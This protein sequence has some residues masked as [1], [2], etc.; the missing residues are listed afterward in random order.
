MINRE[1]THVQA[2]D[3]CGCCHC[4]CHKCMNTNGHCGGSQCGY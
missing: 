2:K 1:S 4:C 3:D